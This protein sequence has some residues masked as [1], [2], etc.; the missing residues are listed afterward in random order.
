MKLVQLLCI[1]TVDLSVI[2]S[3][4]YSVINSV[5]NSVINSVMN[6][7]VESVIDSVYI[8]VINSVCISVVYSVIYY[9]FNYVYKGLNFSCFSPQLVRDSVSKKVL[10]LYLI[11]YFVIYL[12]NNN[13][14]VD[15]YLYRCNFLVKTL[16]ELLVL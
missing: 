11:K 5:F 16:C 1:T 15:Y 4:M 14:C 13:T 7:V 6:S 9:N 3:V 2:N 10:L 12:I 8:S